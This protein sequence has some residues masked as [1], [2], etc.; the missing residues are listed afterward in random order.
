[1]NKAAAAIGCK[2]RGARLAGERRV[3]AAAPGGVGQS[4][5]VGAAP[6]GGGEGGLRGREAPGARVFLVHCHRETLRPGFAQPSVSPECPTSPPSSL[7]ISH[8]AR[9]LC[10]P[11]ARAADTRL[12]PRRPVLSIRRAPAARSAQRG[13]ALPGRGSL[14]TRLG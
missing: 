9:G 3:A 11:T 4:P 6:A 5:A 10:V 1:M 2:A 12:A 13:A 14:S 8:P 7:Q